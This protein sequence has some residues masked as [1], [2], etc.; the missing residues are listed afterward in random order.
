M[1]L[2]YNSFGEGLFSQFSKRVDNF[3]R[4]EKNQQEEELQQIKRELIQV[5]DYK[6][7]DACCE[8]INGYIQKYKITQ[9]SPEA[10]YFGRML[11]I[12]KREI[13]QKNT[14]K[15]PDFLSESLITETYLYFIKDFKDVLSKLSLESPIAKELIDL[16]YR[17]VKND[18]T[19]ISLSDREGYISGSTLRNLKKNIEK[20]FTEW[21]KTANLGDERTKQVLDIKLDKIDKGQTSQTDTNFMFTEYDLGSKSR[22]DVKLGRL[23]NALLPG[24]YGPGDIEEFTNKFK[25]SLSKQSEY[26]KEVSGE[27]ISYWYNSDNYKEMSGQLGNSC[28]AK[29]SG[30]FSLYTENPK[31]C[32]LLIL[33]EDDKL[34]GRA[35]VWKL[36]SIAIYGKEPVQDLW[37][38]DRQYTIADSDV[39]KFKNYAKEKGWIYKSSNNHHSLGNV[40][41]G[42]EEKN[43][44]LTVEVKAKNYSR[45]PYMDTFRRLD[46]NEGI[47]YN[48]D[49]N[50]ESYEGQYI[51][52]DTGGGYEQ[53]ASGVWSEW[54]DRRI[55]EDEAVWSDWADSYLERDSAIYVETGSRRNRDSWYPADCDDIVYDE[56]IDE[57]IHT[58]DAVYSEAYGY[59]IYDQN[60]VEVIGDID[61]DGEATGAENWYH[62]DDDDIIR[63]SAYDDQTWYKVLSEQW[64]SWSDYNWSLRELFI[65][66]YRDEPIPISYQLD[67]YK[68]S[69]D[70]SREL[71]GVDYLSKVDAFIL[72][73]KIDTGAGRLTD[74]FEYTK[75][76]MSIKNMLVSK[77]KTEIKRMSDFLEGSGQ[78]E[79]DFQDQNGDYKELV[80]KRLKEYLKRQS[81]LITRKFEAEL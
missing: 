4:N 30:L 73:L 25:A 68:I 38:M 1:I 3:F 44:T 77:L 59:S 12:I 41:I 28:M 57:P 67:T 11:R 55:P 51:L 56:W 33:V 35:I 53:I 39:E 64:G 6:D 79:L 49:D 16:E 70:K 80:T 45:Y 76:I 62:K 22:N 23:I 29:K 24:K 19:F 10:I 8:L 42:G 17:D 81:E 36:S 5:K 21:A 50:D 27:D 26:F 72:G 74:T 7:F 61:S 52:N 20:S 66:D 75:N 48:D 32:K 37:F 15:Q 13:N 2:K 46:P 63:S 65:L 78:L 40:T 9:Q 14:Y 54:H 71:E 31:V 18:M 69:G 47:L 58:D 60:A 34:I 43:A